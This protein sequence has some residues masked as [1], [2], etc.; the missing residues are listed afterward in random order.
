MFRRR[1]HHVRRT[2]SLQRVPRV[3][4]KKQHEKHLRFV[5]HAPQPAHLGKSRKGDGF[6]FAS[7]GEKSTAPTLDEFSRWSVVAATSTAIRSA[8]SE[9]I[10]IIRSSTSH[11]PSQRHLRKRPCHPTHAIHAFA[12]LKNDI[13]P[14]EVFH[15]AA[16]AESRFSFF[17]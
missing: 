13:R 17:L 9:S 7:R 2:T 6:R 8:P 1:A 12:F 4:Q 5:L 15:R 3:P 11:D 10:V 14:A 16:R